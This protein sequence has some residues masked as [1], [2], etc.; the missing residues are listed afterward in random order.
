MV[1]RHFLRVVPYKHH[2]IHAFAQIVR[3]AFTVVC[4]YVVLRAALTD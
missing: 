2:G 4:A 3:T 1:Q